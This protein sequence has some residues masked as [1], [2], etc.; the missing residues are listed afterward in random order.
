MRGRQELQRE[1]PSVPV[2]DRRPKLPIRASFSA[3]MS[4]NPIADNDSQ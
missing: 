4:D 3:R 1:S 2:N